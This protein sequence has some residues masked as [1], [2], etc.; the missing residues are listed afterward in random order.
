MNEIVYTIQNGNGNVNVCTLK[1]L[2]GFFFVSNYTE[3]KC[4]ENMI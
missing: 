3:S 2:F 1:T 4:I